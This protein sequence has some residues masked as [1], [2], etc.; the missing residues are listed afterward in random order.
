[1]GVGY[2]LARV[3]MLDLFPQTGHLESMALF[4]N[5]RAPEVAAK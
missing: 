5:G 1:M 2:R 4:I 3:W